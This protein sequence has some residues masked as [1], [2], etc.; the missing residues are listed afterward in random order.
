MRHRSHP[1]EVAAHL[2]V[3]LARSRISITL[4]VL[5]AGLSAAVLIPVHGA[6]EYQP[7]STSGVQWL[8]E[9]TPVADTWIQIARP[10]N[11]GARPNKT[12][13]GSDRELRT[14]WW[15]FGVAERT[16]MRFDV[17]TTMPD[18]VVK[19][20]ELELA[21]TAAG[22]GVFSPPVVTSGTIRLALRPVTSRWDEATLTGTQAI[23]TSDVLVSADVAWGPCA[24]G[25]CGTARID[26]TP[27]VHA[28]EQNRWGTY[29]FVMD[30]YGISDRPSTGTLFVVG[31]RES[32]TPPVLR[33]EWDIFDFSTP[34]PTLTPTLAPTLTPTLAPTLT[35]TVP[36]SRLWLPFGMIRQ[37]LS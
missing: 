17:P 7:G 30:A 32:D 29:G 8:T 28:W 6:P 18:T 9:L 10:T 4:A 15:D 27:L 23:T 26:A 22:I 2:V 20:I 12:P 3:R 16:L 13:R 11:I 21:I 19:R 1:I 25:R 31:S 24:N 36:A 34:T 14:G 35:P 33:L 37:Q 5:V